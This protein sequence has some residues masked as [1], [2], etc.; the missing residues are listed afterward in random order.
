M[1]IYEKT[2]NKNYLTKSKRLLK[3]K[4]TKQNDCLISVNLS[5]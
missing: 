3:N 1:G 5:T 4:F 2:L